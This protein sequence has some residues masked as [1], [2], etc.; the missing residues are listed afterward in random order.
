MIRSLDNKNEEELDSQDKYNQNRINFMGSKDELK[1]KEEEEEEEED[2]RE[3][4]T[5]RIDKLRQFIKKCKTSDKYGPYD[6]RTN[7]RCG[8][9][10]TKIENLQT[11]Y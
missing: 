1:K 3:E 11:Y 2:E 7:P 9:E 4:R 10:G 8:V 6:L 5:Y